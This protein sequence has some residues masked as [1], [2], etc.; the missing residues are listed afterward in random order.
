MAHIMQGV[1]PFDGSNFKDWSKDTAIVIDCWRK[2]IIRLM[3]GF[4]RPEDQGTGGTDSLTQAQWNAASRDLYSI[5]YMSTKT[6]GSAAL[7][8]LK[9][10]KADSRS[11]AG[12]NGYEAWDELIKKYNYQSDEVIRT[13]RA[14][15]E[16]V[17]MEPGTD[18]D[19]FFLQAA[20]YR[21]ELQRMGEPVTDRYFKDIIMQGISS[22]YDNIKL[23][24][25]RDPTYKLD[26]IQSTMRNVFRDELSRQSRNT[27]GSRKTVMT[28]VTDNRCK[29]ETNANN[30][31][32]G[33]TMESREENSGVPCSAC[34]GKGHV[35]PE[36][37]HDITC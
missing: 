28:A 21:A 30:R 9:H 7:L 32:T 10:E 37:I 20:R 23:S 11:G 27:I 34:N 6:C 16:G 17:A 31:K 14:K 2:D 12:G 3:E 33:S 1:S 26:E 35:T 25:Y 19:V 5:L 13:L 18:P 4:E 24:V 8:V 29:G 36:E 15:L 22:E